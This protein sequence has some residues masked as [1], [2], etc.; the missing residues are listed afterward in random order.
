MLSV[1]RGHNRRTD[2]RQQIGSRKIRERVAENAKQ[3]IIE[4]SVGER[5]GWLLDV[6]RNTTFRPT[7]VRR[8]VD[9]LQH[10]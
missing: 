1:T 9:L 7:L 5:I 3:A 4:P 6:L 10:D 2:D 8:G